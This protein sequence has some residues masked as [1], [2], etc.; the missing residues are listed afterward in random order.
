MIRRQRTNAGDL[1]E[2]LFENDIGKV[3]VRSN[4]RR[5]HAEQMEVQWHNLSIWT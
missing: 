2:D 5:E 3:P 1:V 4:H